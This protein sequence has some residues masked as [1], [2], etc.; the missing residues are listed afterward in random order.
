MDICVRATNRK[1][2]YIINCIS[3][4]KRLM[5][6]TVAFRLNVYIV[7]SIC[8][9]SCLQNVIILLCYLF[10]IVFNVILHIRL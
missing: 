7:I 2:I 1:E 8:T 6:A 10:V 9:L 5:T 3:S 4:R